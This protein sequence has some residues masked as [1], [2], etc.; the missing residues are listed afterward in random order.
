MKQMIIAIDGPAAS[1]K[2]TVAKTVAKALGYRYLDTGAMYR[3]YTLFVINRN[4]DSYNEEEVGRHVHEARIEVNGSQAFLNGKEVTKDIRSTQ[5]TSL[6]SKVC[7]YA[8]VRAYMV[9]EQRRLAN[10]GKSGVVLD[11]RDIGT[12]VFP[13]ADLKIFLT[14]S[15]EVRANRRYLENIERGINTSLE[16][17]KTDLLR[18]DK[19]DSTREISPL[20]IAYDAIYLDNSAMNTD[21]TAQFVLDRF[22]EIEERNHA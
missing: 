6:V 10:D 14:A 13:N 4:I 11:G 20:S 8:A 9:E 5:V 17:I 16:E 12:Y 3:C 7:S 18:R 1:G 2:S 15:Y 22:K 19:E 21:E